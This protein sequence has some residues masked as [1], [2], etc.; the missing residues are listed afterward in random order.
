M[1]PLDT[2]KPPLEMKRRPGARWVKPEFLAEIAFRAL[3][4]NG[5]LRHASYKGLREG[6]DEAST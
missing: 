6:E 1:G 4:D 2:D 3:T 5:T